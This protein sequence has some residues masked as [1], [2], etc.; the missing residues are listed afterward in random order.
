MTPVG[1]ALARHTNYVAAMEKFRQANAHSPHWA[2]PLEHWG[3][4]LA[5]QGKH[6]EAIE[7][8][9]AAHS[10]APNWA[11][12][13]RM[14]PPFC[15]FPGPRREADSGTRVESRRPHARGSTTQKRFSRL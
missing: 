15:S 1:E 4:A 8:Y 13:L 6:R 14:T 7:K 3:E 12:S 5:A 11:R 9:N 10:Y 2:D